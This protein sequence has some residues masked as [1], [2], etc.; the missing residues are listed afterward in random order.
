MYVI[1]ELI[2]TCIIIYTTPNQFITSHHH[3]MYTYIQFNYRYLSYGTRYGTVFLS[4]WQ[5]E[6]EKYTYNSDL[7]LKLSDHLILLYS[8]LFCYIQA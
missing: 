6:I 7:E 2:L 1:D 3:H 4:I 5:R 8:I